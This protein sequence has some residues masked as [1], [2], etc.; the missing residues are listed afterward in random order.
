VASTELAALHTD[1]TYNP[2]DPGE[3]PE[4]LCQ[5]GLD[6]AEVVTK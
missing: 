2:I 1:D 6:G 3:L 4:R 5:A